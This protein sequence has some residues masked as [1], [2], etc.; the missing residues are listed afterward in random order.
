MSEVLRLYTWSEYLSDEVVAEFEQSTGHKI[1]LTYYDSEAFRDRVLI[2]LGDQFDLILYDSYS[3]NTFAQ[4]G[5][6]HALDQLDIKGG[7]NQLYKARESCGAWGVP[8]GHGT[9]GIAYRSS[10]YPDGVS[11]WRSLLE[12]S[13][14]EGS[15][16]VMPL[17]EID[18]LAIIRVY[19]G[20][21][22]Y[23]EDSESMERAQEILLAQQPNVL[24]Y[25]YGMTYAE[26]HGEDS[27]M[28]LTLAYSGDLY[29]ITELTG[30]DDWNYVVPDEG[31]LLW[32]DCWAAASAKPITP[33]AKQFLQYLNQ[34]E[35]AAKNAEEVWF[36]TS[37]L[38]AA[39]HLS[40]EYLEDEEL[41]P[42]D[43]VLARAWSGTPPKAWAE[44]VH[45]WFIE[46]TAP[47]T[48]EESN[49]FRGIDQND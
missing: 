7:G 43:E 8:Y 42:S 10:S 32:V 49:E 15:G 44:Q 35:V 21:P 41:F 46:S 38:A 9:T 14:S 27:E 6:F 1:E 3:L 18:T 23:A 25:G 5:Y 34:P 20:L 16:V 39:P 12:P 47:L 31:T 11:S 37:N 48:A 24:S 45:D 13:P 30:Q 26:E 40:D 19:L 28:A 2:S 36:A 4:E 22:P 17:D 29:S 33:A